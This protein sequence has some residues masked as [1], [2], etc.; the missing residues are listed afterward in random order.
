M[1]PAPLL[2]AALGAALALDH[3]ACVSLLVSQPLV[4][5]ALFGAVAGNFEGAVAAGALVQLV[6]MVPLRVGGARV[7]EAWLG[8]AAAA[9]AAPPDIGREWMAAAS[10]TPAVTLGVAAA[11]AAAPLVAWQRRWQSAR[12]VGVVAR[13]ERGDWRA[14]ASAQHQAMAVHALRGAVLGLGAVVLAPR[15]AAVLA[16]PLAG[17]AAGWVALPLAVVALGRNTRGRRVPWW[18]CG[19]AI[20]AACA[21]LGGRS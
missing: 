4:A 3:A 13:A 14:V 21:W 6:W 20:G 11:L 12:A 17:V 8:G 18:L 16:Q 1:N 10:L 2:G 5:A 9:M 15:L 7:P 19:L